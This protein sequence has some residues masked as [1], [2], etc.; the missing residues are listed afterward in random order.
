MLILNDGSG[1]DVSRWRPAGG[2][3]LTRVSVPG[4]SWGS[5]RASLPINDFFF[6]AI[7]NLKTED[8]LLRRRHA[9]G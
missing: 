2:L 4:L 5:G 9:R 6:I 1:R 7:L 8:L 3:A